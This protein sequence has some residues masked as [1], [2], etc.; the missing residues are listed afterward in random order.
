M[1]VEPLPQN[2]EDR[3]LHLFNG[4]GP[5]KTDLPS[6][7]AWLASDPSSDNRAVIIKRVPGKNKARATESLALLHPNI[8]RTRRWI[9]GGD[10]FI[11]VLRDV[12]KGKNLR[13]S[14]VAP[15]GCARRRS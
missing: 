5:L 2:T 14:L 4:V 7:K 15:G 1:P 6:A 12:V 3:L 10:G 9:A 8:A 13:E 11:Y